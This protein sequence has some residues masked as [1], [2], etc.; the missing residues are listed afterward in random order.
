MA[1]K[2]AKDKVL[3][4][5]ELLEGILLCLGP[6]DLLRMKGVNRRFRA[7][8]KGSTSIHQALF[9]KPFE[10]SPKDLFWEWETETKTLKLKKRSEDVVLEDASDDN[11]YNNLGLL[12]V[13]NPFVVGGSAW[14]FTDMI[15]SRINS[16]RFEFSLLN[17]PQHIDARAVCRNMLLAYPPIDSF[18]I[19]HAGDN[20]SG[21]REIPNPQ[22]VTYGDVLREYGRMQGRAKGWR[23]EDMRVALPIV[24]LSDEEHT[25]LHRN[26]AIKYDDEGKIEAARTA[27]ATTS[28]TTDAMLDAGQTGQAS[29]SSD[30]DIA[31][32]AHGE[33]GVQGRLS[34]EGASADSLV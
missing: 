26:G 13:V 28:P 8:M 23:S 29:I 9:L 6:V 3:G 18:E 4:T 12:R 2:M 24:A 14:N 25:L 30:V 17:L 1:I 27:P 10:S 32:G 7:V 16:A 19:W 34:E 5:T 15:E 21:T 31:G 33:D 11:E 20:D 22:G